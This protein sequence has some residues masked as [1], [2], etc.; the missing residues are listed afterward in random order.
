MLWSS[1]TPPNNA[2]SSSS[3]STGKRACLYSAWVYGNKKRKIVNTEGTVESK[4]ICFILIFI[5]LTLRYP[6]L[7]VFQLDKY[8]R[9]P[10][11]RAC[12]CEFVINRLEHRLLDVLR[13]TLELFVD[14]QFQI[15]NGWKKPFKKKVRK[16]SESEP[17][18][19]GNLN[20]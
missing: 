20:F 8:R 14:L 10:N 2:D 19:V 5:N 3:K 16:R 18:Y 4:N 6:H 15:K 7:H 1:S 12:M 17:K 13:E 9:H 11:A